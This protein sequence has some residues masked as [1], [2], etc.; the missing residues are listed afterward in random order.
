MKDANDYTYCNGECNDKKLRSFWIRPMLVK[1][2]RHCI[3][4]EFKGDKDDV[5]IAE[6]ILKCEEHGGR[7]TAV[8]AL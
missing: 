6:A 2:D 1:C 3:S 7:C 4:P 8:F 5:D